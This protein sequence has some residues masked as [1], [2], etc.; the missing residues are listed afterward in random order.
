M[1]ELTNAP[2]DAYCTSGFSPPPALERDQKL[3]LI[4]SFAERHNLKI[5]L[6]SCRN[7]IIPGKKTPTG[8][9]DRVEYRNHIYEHG[10]D[11][12]LGVCLMFP[13]KARWTYA[14]K[15]LLAAGFVIRLDGDTEGTALFDPA[16][17]QQARLAI[18]IVGAKRRRALTA[19][20]RLDRAA[21]LK[22]ARARKS[23]MV[24]DAP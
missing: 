18:R 6:D 11:G 17:F 12:T 16:D 20:D 5:K 2:S 24:A 9:S 15:K 14:K 7:P 19:G 23:E 10:D 3:G 22:R 8:M 4:Q 13:T 21:R 1:T